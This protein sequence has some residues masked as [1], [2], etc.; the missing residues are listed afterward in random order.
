MVSFLPNPVSI[1][2]TSSGFRF[3]IFDAP[4]DENLEMYIRELKKHAVQHVVRAC[5]ITYDA[6]RLEAAGIQVT[7]V[8][9]KDGDPPPAD[10]L[11]KFSNT[12]RQVIKA[13]QNAIGVHCVAGLGRA[14]VLVA[15]ALVDEGMDPLDAIQAI[16]NK[17]KGAINS[18][19]LNWLRTYKKKTDGC[20][21]M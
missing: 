14:P 8:M 15:T 3:V 13:E 1:V 4:N 6:S 5:E 20:V 19:Q 17:R 16:R 10:V 12:V 18:K 2:E 9:F 21:L 11:A 7:T